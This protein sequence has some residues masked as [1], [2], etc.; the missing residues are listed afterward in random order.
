MKRKDKL[1][2]QWM[3]KAGL[4]PEAVPKEAPRDITPELDKRKRRLRL[5]Y[6]LLG[7]SVMILCAG[8]VMLA[9]HS[10]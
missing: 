3:D 1:Y 10:G 5:L 2:Q 7:V 4:P 8:L 9:L 6:I